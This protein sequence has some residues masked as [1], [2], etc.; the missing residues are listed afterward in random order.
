MTPRRLAPLIAVSLLCACQRSQDRVTEEIIERAIGAGGRESKVSV[1]RERGS[2]QID[3]GAA[4]TPDGWPPVVP[5]YPRAERAKIESRSE[6]GHRLSVVSAD[7]VTQ[8]SEYYRGEL[9]HRGWR[10]EPANAAAGADL[11]ARKGGE[12]VEVRFSKRSRDRGSRAEIEY[13]VGVAG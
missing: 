12:T 3:L 4:T 2:I 1:D 5:I 7:S 13:R 6:A 9:A 10:V 11:H 8:L